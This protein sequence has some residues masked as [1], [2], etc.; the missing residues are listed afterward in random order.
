VVAAPEFGKGRALRP[1]PAGLGLCETSG[2][3]NKWSLITI[4]TIKSFQ[5]FCSIE[6]TLA[7]VHPEMSP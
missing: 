5:R 1:S 2:K 3:I 6:S 7:P 4:K